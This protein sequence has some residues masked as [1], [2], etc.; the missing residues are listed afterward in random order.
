MLAA[1]LGHP[2]RAYPA[3]HIAGTN[4]K[5]STAA[6]L[7]SILSAAGLR[8]GLYTS[9]HLQRVNER[10]RV[11]GAEISDEDF[12]ATFTHLHEIIE[13]LLAS[14][15]L[16]AHPTF[17]ECL[18][19]MAFRFFADSRVDLAVF[20]VGM[21][22]RLDATNIIEPE[23]AVIT[24]I[25]FDHENFLGHSIEQIAGEKAGIIKPGALVLSA[26]SHPAAKEVIRRHAAAQ[27]ARLVE[28]DAAWDAR[29][30]RADDG[31]Y[32]FVASPLAGGAAA[33]SPEIAIA[34]PLA[35]RFQVRNALT[36]VAAARL[37]AEREHTAGRAI[38]DASIA[39]GLAAVRWPG[40]LERLQRRPDVYLDGT[41]N[42][43]GARALV[44]FWEEQF[45]GRRIHLVYGALRDKAVDEVAGLLFPR[46][47]TVIITQSPQPR[48]ISAQTLAAMTNH[49]AKRIE[50]IPETAAALEF[51]LEQAAPEDAVFATG[52]LY[53][54]GDLRQYWRGRAPNRSRPS[55]HPAAAPQ[56]LGAV[57][58][59][60][61]VGRKRQA[62]EDHEPANPL[63]GHAL[64]SV[65]AG[66]ASQRRANGHYHRLR[67]VDHVRGDKSHRRAAVDGAAP[68]HVQGIHGMDLGHP[69]CGKYSEVDDPDAG[70][71]IAAIDSHQNLNKSGHGDGRIRGV[72]GD[73]TRQPSRQSVAKNEEER[74]AQQQPR[75]Q[76]QKRAWTCANQ[77]ERAGE[78]PQNT[79][80]Q[81][82]DYHPARQ[83]PVTAITS[84][85][86][87]ASKSESQRV[88]GVGGHRRNAGKHQHRKGKEGSA[89]G[90]GVNPAGNRCGEEYQ[91]GVRESQTYFV[92]RRSTCAGFIGRLRIAARVGRADPRFQLRLAALDAYYELHRLCALLLAKLLGLQVQKLLEVC[93]G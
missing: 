7:A 31:C 83:V 36:A 13:E 19:A 37:L 77:E 85:A 21:G 88:G 76:Q 78:R 4:G 91:N 72:P 53:L 41:H 15:Q 64:R 18:T 44:E 2:E 61:E 71:E 87:H 90:E 26:A 5:G 73:T 35:G 30:L 33:S 81:Q 82:R 55:E 65:G 47:A 11:G 68:R 93:R 1:S 70:S 63:L 58:P 67:P 34:L 14:G 75:H 62:H 54:V 46:A 56:Q 80:H 89:A 23:V 50:V 40:R 38:N 84:R 66:I 69:E 74:R 57:K 43:A 52:S 45:A 3:V 51:A 92:P 32:R 28:L 49:L 12:A 9:P 20:E 25:D 16:A 60:K 6:M 27:G 79:R 48:A 86:A 24:Q 59:V 42:P 17:F 8:V 10:I 22:G 29:D 39:A